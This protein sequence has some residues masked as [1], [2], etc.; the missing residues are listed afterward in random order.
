MDQDL[1]EILLETA[2]RADDE[3]G[4]LLHAA[5]DALRSAATRE[6]DYRIVLEIIAGRRPPHDPDLDHAELAAA[7]LDAYAG[8]SA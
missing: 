1:I 6:N 8:D 7:A 4:P 3:I 5:V 2:E